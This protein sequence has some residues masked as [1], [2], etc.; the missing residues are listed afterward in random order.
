MAQC[1]GRGQ[2]T[3]TNEFLIKFACRRLSCKH[4][5][6]TG[7]MPAFCEVLCMVCPGCGCVSCVRVCL[8]GCVVCV[9]VRVCVRVLVLLA[10][11]IVLDD[12][13][14]LTERSPLLILE[15]AHIYQMALTVA[16]V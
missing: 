1:A 7:E 6:R 2:D 9:C 15:A 10:F 5:S 4:S 12:K 3:G 14:R 13:F 11:H 16:A 8:C